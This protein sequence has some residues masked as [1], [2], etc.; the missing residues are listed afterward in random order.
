MPKLSRRDAAR[1]KQAVRNVERSRAGKTGGGQVKRIARGGKGKPK[2]NGIAKL[3]EPLKKDREASAE[4]LKKIEGDGTEESPFTYVF[5]TD[6]EK[7]IKVTALD[8]LFASEQYP[9]NAIVGWTERLGKKV[10]DWT[11]G[12]AVPAT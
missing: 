7:R 8:G 6:P 11:N 12:C 10:I 9:T 5:E 1:L 4:P 2:E 3:K